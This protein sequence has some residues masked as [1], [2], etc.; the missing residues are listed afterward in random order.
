NEHDNLTEVEYYLVREF[1]LNSKGL[2]QRGDSVKK[3]KKR[4]GSASS[5]TAASAEDGAEG[6]RSRSVSRTS[7]IA[8]EDCFEVEG[9]EPER[10]KI[11]ILGA[12]GVGKTSLTQ[13][14]TRTALVDT[15]DTD[16]AD[17]FTEVVVT[18]SV[19]GDETE[20][21]FHSIT[22]DQI[23]CLVEDP[24]IDGALVV[25]SLAD[26]QTYVFAED[27]LCKIRKHLKCTCPVVLVANKDDLVRTRVVS[28]G[29]GKLVATL[30][31]AKY[32]ETSAVLSYH[33]DELLV[34]ILHQIKSRKS[35][36]K[37][38]SQGMVRR[39][40]AKRILKRLMSFHH[41]TTTPDLVCN[42]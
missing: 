18:V 4:I 11:V 17:K 38:P 30:Y 5:D 24:S 40:S 16:S 12:H 39:N 41:G 15:F 27:V 34:G 1:S 14:F 25:Y 23:P 20:L 8:S 32:I 10:F 3:R 42:D 33:V 19:D 31:D 7:S 37:A 26:R 9:S 22:E 35:P 36:F 13:Q 28:C 2:L 21:S 6:P 29:E